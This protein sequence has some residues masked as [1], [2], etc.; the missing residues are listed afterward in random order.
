[1][2]RVSERLG[3]VDDSSIRNVLTELNVRRN[4][5]LK[6]IEEV[7]FELRQLMTSTA[8]VNSKIEISLERVKGIEDE[9]ERL[10]SELSQRIAQAKE[11]EIKLKSIE[12]ELKS[13]RDQ[14]Q[15][16]IDSSALIYYNARI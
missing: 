11:L 8:G 3:G 9:N 2:K 1:M 5:F 16:I 12:L 7:D 4:L 10:I 6:S 14:E 13:I 15:Q